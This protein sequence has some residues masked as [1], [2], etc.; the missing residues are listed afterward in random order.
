MQKL[1]SGY[2]NTEGRQVMLSFEPDR[3]VFL[4]TFGY[5]INI[6]PFNPDLCREWGEPSLC[7]CILIGL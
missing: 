3:L 1:D 4:A 5:N 6:V 2:K 7:A